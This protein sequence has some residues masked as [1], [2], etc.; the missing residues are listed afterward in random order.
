MGLMGLDWSALL[1]LIGNAKSREAIID[2]CRYIEAGAI[3]GDGERI[4]SM[5]ERSRIS[6]GNRDGG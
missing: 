6:Q 3:E 5:I 4:K 2:A 1:A